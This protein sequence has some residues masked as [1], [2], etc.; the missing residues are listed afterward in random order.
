MKGS[1]EHMLR[2]I[3]IKLQYIH[4]YLP[5]QKRK[6]RRRKHGK[7]HQTKTVRR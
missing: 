2:I 1:I 5:L 3:E 4:N 7:F 6:K